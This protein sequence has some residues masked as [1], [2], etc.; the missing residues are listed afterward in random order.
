M[1]SAYTWTLTASSRSVEQQCRPALRGKPVGVVPFA[2]ATHS[3]VIACSRE[4]KLLGVKNVMAIEEAR[5]LCPEIILV[6]QSPDL[7]RRAHNTLISEIAD[8]RS[9]RCGEVD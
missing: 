7:Y 6:P 5:A 1:S 2:E 9:D 8:G 3:C 4:A